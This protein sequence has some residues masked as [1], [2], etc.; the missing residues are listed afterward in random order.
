MGAQNCVL[1][2][3]ICS[4]MLFALNTNM[5]LNSSWIIFIHEQVVVPLV[6]SDSELHLK[7]WLI[8]I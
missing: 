8:Y 5:E 4:K 1:L 7:F 6:C 3:P 2:F